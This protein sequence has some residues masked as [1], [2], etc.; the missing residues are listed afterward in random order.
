MS[1]LHATLIQEGFAFEI[2][3]FPC[4]QFGAQEPGTNHE[5]RALANSYNA[6]FVIT[7]KVMVQGAQQHPAF[8]L[9]CAKLPGLLGLQS[10]KWNFTKFLFDSKGTP[11]KRYA[12]TTSPFEM[13]AD[14]RGL[15]RADL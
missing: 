12:P 10:I 9:A 8:A 15:L 14:I 2:V 3:A 4:N 1:E 13:E 6:K 7:D 5:I 11:F